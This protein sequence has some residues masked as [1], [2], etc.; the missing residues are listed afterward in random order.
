VHYRPGRGGVE[1]GD[2]GAP[3]GGW[4]PLVLRVSG[5][6]VLVLGGGS[7][8]GR[9][10]L[11]FA[12]GGARVRVAALEFSEELRRAAA[13]GEVELVR[14]DL[15]D[16]RELRGLIAWADLVVVATS[17]P[18]V[19]RAA[20]A[21]A[22]ELGKLVNDATEAGR[23]NVMV[24]FHRRIERLGITVA[25]TS[26]GRAGVAARLALERCAETLEGDAE[27]YTIAHTMAKLKEW[28]KS[29]EPDP[30]R[31]LPIYFMV[32]EDPEYRRLARDG[33]VDEALRR[34]LA[35]ASTALGVKS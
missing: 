3:L 35:I 18:E 6:R 12:S 20:S 17:D 31:R 26:L 15:R 14:A 5:L 13:G 10:A 4:M 33:L 27:L 21:L 7:V 25:V 30:K 8:G 28:L 32:A 19:N 23:G 2:R 29:V 22:L 11:Q 16:A 1:V 9:R 34:A 24:P